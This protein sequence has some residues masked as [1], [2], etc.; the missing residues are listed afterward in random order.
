[1]TFEEMDALF[2][3]PATG[4]NTTLMDSFK[5]PDGTPKMLPVATNITK[6]TQNDT[7][8]YD[9]DPSPVAF[10]TFTGTATNDNY[11]LYIKLQPNMELY[12]YFIDYLYADMPFYLAYQVGIKLYVTPETNS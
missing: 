5:N 2:Q 4:E 3:K 10:D 6:T 9:A 7:E 1:M 12:K 8:I 11:Y